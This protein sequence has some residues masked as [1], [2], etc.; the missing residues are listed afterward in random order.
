MNKRIMYF[1]LLL[2]VMLIFTGCKS[3]RATQEQ[4][5][6]NN[7]VAQQNA[8]SDAQEDVMPVRKEFIEFQDQKYAS[9]GKYYELLRNSTLYQNAESYLE[10]SQQTI[11]PLQDAGSYLDQ[12]VV[13]TVWLKADGENAWTLAEGRY[14]GSVKLSDGKYEMDFLVAAEPIG[15]EATPTASAE[16]AV[17]DDGLGELAG[18]QHITGYLAE[19]GSQAE[20]RIYA[21]KDGKDTALQFQFELIDK[22]NGEYWTQYYY[23]D[24]DKGTALNVARE[25]IRDDAISYAIFLETT[26][27]PSSLFDRELNDGLFDDADF[28][29]VYA[30]GKAQVY[31]QMDLYYEFK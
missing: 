6:N 9:L 28:R 13:C 17:T 1:T 30:G 3:S 26:G 8:G 20:I 2:C 7:N 19:D 21:R 4:G 12:A 31:E 22:G 25:H 27:K 10:F 24:T 15:A 5:G 16:V 23:A 11:A 14:S 29:C 18:Q